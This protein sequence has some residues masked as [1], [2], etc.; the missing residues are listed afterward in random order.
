M[1]SG[2]YVALR[3]SERAIGLRPLAAFAWEPEPGEQ[4][5]G[6]RAAAAESRCRDSAQPPYRFH[7]RHHAR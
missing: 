2:S 3:T 4:P 1:L 7:S 5:A 6:S